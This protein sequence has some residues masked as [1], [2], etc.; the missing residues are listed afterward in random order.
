[1]VNTS[2][3]IS[4]NMYWVQ[5][6]S[7]YSR[8]ILHVGTVPPYQWRVPNG[9]FG[10]PGCPSVR[11]GYGPLSWSRTQGTMRGHPVRKV[12]ICVGAPNADRFARPRR[13]TTITII[14]SEVKLNT[15]V[16]SSPGFHF[17]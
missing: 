7:N 6:I 9:P 8:K 11:M 14:K 13:Q 17:N 12:K 2:I 5:H 4:Q 3:Q 10:I 15:S 1:M 16:T